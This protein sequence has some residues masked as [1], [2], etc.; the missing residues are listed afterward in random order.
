MP[1]GPSNTSNHIGI[2]ATKLY[3]RPTLQWVGPRAGA[4]GNGAGEARLERSQVKF[5][6][7]LAEDRSMSRIDRKFS[8]QVRTKPP[9]TNAQEPFI[10]FHLRMAGPPI[11]WRRIP[12]PIRVN[13][14]LDYTRPTTSAEST[15][16]P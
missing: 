7:Q 5:H 6:R 15:N 4:A 10:P 16:E 11:D 1:H 3:K 14:L 2:R 8:R 9:G 13:V 12:S